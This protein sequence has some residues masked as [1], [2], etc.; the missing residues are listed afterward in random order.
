MRARQHAGVDRDRT[1]FVRLAA[2]DAEP[3]VEHLR[4]QLVVLDV[5]EH[6]LDILA[7]LG[8]VGGQRFG[9]FLL[10]AL[11]G[12]DAAV[13][14]LLVERFLDLALGERLDPRGELVGDL[15]LDPLHLLRTLSADL[16]DAA[17]PARRSA[18]ECPS[19]RP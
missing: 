9:D 12:L 17:P 13:L 7:A 8:E 6:G 10:H 16:L 3:C 19:A 15:R 4:A 5:A 14:V 18:R 11:D 1:D 2:V